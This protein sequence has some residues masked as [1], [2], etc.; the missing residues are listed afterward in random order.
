MDPVVSGPPCTKTPEHMLKGTS[1]AC[2]SDPHCEDFSTV[3]LLNKSSL[4]S[5]LI[6]TWCR[7]SFVLQANACQHLPTISYQCSW[8]TK[9]RPDFGLWGI[10]GE[11][12]TLRNHQHKTRQLNLKCNSEIWRRSL[13]WLWSKYLHRSI[14]GPSPKVQTHNA[15]CFQ[16][17]TTWKT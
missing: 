3:V 14:P 16:R 1:E 2:H 10:Q 13:R 11:R 8:L 6:H 4:K 12:A 7:H 9:S 17:D 15:L 5:M